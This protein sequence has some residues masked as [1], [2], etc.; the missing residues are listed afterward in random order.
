MI[1]STNLRRNWYRKAAKEKGRLAALGYHPEVIRLYGLALRD[2]SRE[3]RMRRF[4]Q[5][6]EEFKNAP[7]QLRLFP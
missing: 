6:F 3:S 4:E 1:R 7:E 5:A 2:L